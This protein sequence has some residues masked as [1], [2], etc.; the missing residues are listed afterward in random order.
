MHDKA[1]AFEALD[2]LLGVLHGW[3]AS[4]NAHLPNDTL[5]SLLDKDCQ[6]QCPIH[7]FFYQRQTKKY[8][9]KCSETSHTHEHQNLFSTTI[10]MI[11]VIETLGRVMTEQP[12]EIFKVIKSHKNMMP[13][14][15]H[16]LVEGKQECCN[17]RNNLDS[18]RAQQ[19]KSTSHNG[20]LSSPEVFLLNL[21]WNGEPSPLEILKVLVSI[22]N[23]FNTRDLF[24]ETA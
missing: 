16:R 11:E 7:Q 13:A 22:P 20:L 1:D 6:A 12:G 2:K 23:T 15:R 24:Q 19:H 10:N 17:P 8:T 18:T 4:T 21:Q 14:I 5:F 9:C 3:L